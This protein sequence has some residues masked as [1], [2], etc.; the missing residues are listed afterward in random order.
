MSAPNPYFFFARRTGRQ[1]G[2]NAIAWLNQYAP[3]QSPIGQGVVA[4]QYAAF[5]A[6]K[7]FWPYASVRGGIAPYYM[8]YSGLG[9]IIT[10]TMYYNA[11]PFDPNA[12]PNVQTQALLQPL[13]PQ[14]YQPPAG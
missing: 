4:G 2:A 8:P 14:F 10:G 11:P 6:P 1:P 13:N 7:V 12:Q 3:A 9:G 5:A